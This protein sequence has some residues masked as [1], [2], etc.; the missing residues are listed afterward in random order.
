MHACKRQR[1][2]TSGGAA[3]GAARFELGAQLG[4]F[5]QVVVARRGGADQFHFRRQLGVGDRKRHV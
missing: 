3:R 2:V 1:C 5:G 4:G